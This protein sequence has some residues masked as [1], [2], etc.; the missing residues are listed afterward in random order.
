MRTAEETPT[1]Q[2]AAT[3]ILK[4]PAGPE[5]PR[6]PV[7]RSMTEGTLAAT[8]GGRGIEGCRR[9]DRMHPKMQALSSQ[10]A[11]SQEGEATAWA[12]VQDGLNE[13]ATHRDREKRLQEEV[14]RLQEI[15]RRMESRDEG[16]RRTGGRNQ[17]GGGGE[18]AGREQGRDRGSGGGGGRGGERRTGGNTRDRGGDGHTNY[19]QSG[20][21]GSNQGGGGRQGGGNQVHHYQPKEGGGATEAPTRDGAMPQ[22]TRKSTCRRGARE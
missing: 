4:D 1:G 5:E 3:P 2:G 18:E 7:Q 14:D 19:R 8:E 13:A 20:Y 9:C 16:N 15:Q 10:L 22:D 11:R 21:R 12:L 17:D 6:E